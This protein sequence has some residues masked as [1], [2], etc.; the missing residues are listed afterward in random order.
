M[1]KRSFDDVNDGMPGDDD[2]RYGGPAYHRS[3][4]PNGTLFNAVASSSTLAPEQPLHSD[5]DESYIVTPEVAETLFKEVH[6]RILNTMQPLYQLPA[7]EEEVKV[8][9]PFLPPLS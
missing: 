2:A 3:N 6:G 8:R 9:P 7:D 1:P 5:D 4:S